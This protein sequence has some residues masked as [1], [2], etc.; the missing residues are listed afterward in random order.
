MP[1]TFYNANGQRLSTR[2]SAIANLDINGGAAIGE[3]VVGADLFIMDNGAGGTNVKVTANEVAT[4]IAAPT[5]ASKAN[6]ESQTTGTLYAPPDLV[7]HA[8]GVAKAWGSSEDSGIRTGSYGVTSS[9]KDA[10]GKY[11]WT[12][13]VD[14][15]DALYVPVTN[16]ESG[17]GG[18]FDINTRAEST[19]AFW[20]YNNAGALVNSGLFVVA[21]G[22]Q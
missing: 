4:F 18:G 9:A 7:R 12:W 15:A 11:T 1:W 3:A 14:F 22:T 8:P 13:A 20:S 2:S 10:T 21:F 19:A 17:V 5:E 6:M 16:S